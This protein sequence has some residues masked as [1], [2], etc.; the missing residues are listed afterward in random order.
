M[1]HQFISAPPI[2]P[3][4]SPARTPAAKSRARLLLTIL[5]L[6][7]SALGIGRWW[8]GNVRRHWIETAS[9]DELASAASRDGGDVAVF[10]QLAARASQA[11]QWPR[12]AKA[13]QRACEIA[14]DHVGNWVGW[15]RAI[16]EFGGF[17]PADAILSGYIQN[18]PRESRA[19][20]ERAALRRDAKRTEMAWNDA[21]QAARLDPASGTAW[22]LRGDLCL[23]QGIA[24]EAVNSFRKAR[25]LM[26]ASA[27]PQVGLYQAYINE[28]Q[29]EDALATARLIVARFPQIIE[30]NLYL[31]E[32]LIL[33]AKSSEDNE[34]ARRALTEASKRSSEMRRMDQS[35]LQFLLGRTYFNQARWREALVHFEQADTIA[36]GNPDTLFLMGRAYRA[37]GETARAEATLLRHKQVYEQTASLRQFQAKINANPNDAAQRLEFAR[38]Y[39][40]H[41]IPQNASIQYEE[42]IARG[43]EVET[44]R[45][46][47][48]DLEKNGAAK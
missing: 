18:H 48:K 44:A 17:Q 31:G 29:L 9:L 16:Y 15:S 21:D 33:S 25:A 22:A 1:F 28:K 19:Y 13:Y 43:L 12:A 26:P 14:P 42:M 5:F 20:L 47:M 37:V 38:W 4:T 36:P 39:T 32:A 7:V 27:W 24:E 35:A 3:Q 6:S 11:E 46:E 10:E 40:R 8:Q 23:D 2:P 45:R 41:G 30:S 34:T